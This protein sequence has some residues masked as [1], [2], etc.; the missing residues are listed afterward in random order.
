MT[1]VPSKATAREY[2]YP[3]SPGGK[4]PL[5][6]SQLKLGAVV[7]LMSTWSY[8]DGGRPAVGAIFSKRLTV[9]EAPRTAGPTDGFQ[10]GTRIV[11]MMDSLGNE[12]YWTAQQLGCAPLGDPDSPQHNNQFIVATGRTVRVYSPSA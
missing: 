1:T 4:L 2:R 8:L 3:L 11:K 9:R 12:K 10:P 5:T 6:W 7:E